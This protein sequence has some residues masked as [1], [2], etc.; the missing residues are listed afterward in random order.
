MEN[1]IAVY[2]DAIDPHTCQSIIKYYEEMNKIHASYSRQYSEGS[3]PLEKKDNSINVVRPVFNENMVLVNGDPCIHVVKNELYTAMNDYIE[4]FPD[5]ANYNLQ[6]LH[7]KVQKTLPGGG[8]HV[9]HSEWSPEYSSR[10]V[11]YTI[12]LNDVEEGGET[13]F[14]YQH[15][16]CPAKQGTI[17]FFPAAYTHVHRGNPPLSGEKYIMTGWFEGTAIPEGKQIVMSN[18]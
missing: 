4:K 14:L 2:E 9:W 17:C 6:A 18:P 1:F 11:V 8:Y 12:Y 15:V 3:S 7:H 16:R 10:A 5:L 13:E